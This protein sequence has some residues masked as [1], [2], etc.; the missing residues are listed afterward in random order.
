MIYSTKPRAFCADMRTRVLTI[1]LW[2]TACLV[3]P[4][5]AFAGGSDY[6][7]KDNARWIPFVA[8]GFDATIHTY[9]LATED[10]TET[11]SEF[12]LQAGIEGRS[13]R[14]TAHRWR[15]RAEAST[16]SEMFRERLDGSYRYINSEGSTRLRLKGHFWGRQYKDS[17]T[18]TLSSDNFESRFDARVY[19]LVTETVALECRGW[20][21]LIDYKQPST[22]EADYQDRGMGVFARSQGFSTNMWS[23]GTRTY[24]RDYPDS[25]AIGR[26]VISLEGNF[27]KYNDKGQGL[28]VFHKS[29]RRLAA[30][31]TIRPSAWSQWTDFR[32]AVEASS[33]LVFLELQGESWSYDQETSVYFN[34]W[35]VDGTMGYR[36]GDILGTT[37][38]AGFSAEKL[39]AGDSPEAY[40]QVGLVAGLESFG[41]DVSGSVTMEYGRRIYA[42]PDIDIS[43]D[44]DDETLDSTISLYSDFNYWQIWVMGSWFLNDHFSLDA[45]ASYEPESHTEQTDDSALGFGSLRLTWRP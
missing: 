9:P 17:T 24:R 16:G 25:T 4:L 28:S 30:D 44:S 7:R 43:D 18:Y 2:G 22:L 26:D 42:H 11:I 15:L 6:S 38:H 31:E 35:R 14:K 21:S 19:P 39:A 27:E 29:E 5:L 34:S 8:S 13:K 12:R 32:G 1:F 20:V 10:T 23:L 45:M 36:G 33:G 3:V 37:W 40:T 41:S